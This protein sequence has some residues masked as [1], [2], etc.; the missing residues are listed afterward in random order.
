MKRSALAAAVCSLAM[1]QVV[2][3][4]VQVGG[5][6]NSTLVH[7]AIDTNQDQA[8]YADRDTLQIR[9]QVTAIYQSKKLQ[10]TATAAHLYQK[11]SIDEGSRSDSFSQFNYGANLSVIDNTWQVF[12]GGSQSYRAIQPNAYLSSDFLLNSNDLSKITTHSAGTSLNIQP[13]DFW[14]AVGTVRYYNVKSDGTASDNGDDLNPSGLNS[15]G[16]SGSLS[17]FNGDWFRNGYW[18][19][20]GVF[21]SVDR[22]NSGTY[23]S[24]YATG[25]MGYN[26]ISDFGIVLTASHEENDI[27]GELGAGLAVFNS[28]FGRFNTYGVGINYRPASSR[29]FMITANKISTDGDDDG[30]TFVGV[31]LQWQFSARTRVAGQ[32]TRRYYGEAGTFNFS[33]GTRAVRTSLTYSES[34]TT[35]SRL[36]Y[37]LADAGSFV[38]GIDAVDISD[39][40]QP[41]TLD[42]ELQ[43]GEQLVQF[44]ELVSEINEQLILRRQLGASIGFDRRKLKVALETRYVDTQYSETDRKQITKLIAINGSFRAGARTQLTS[45][46]AYSQVENE[47]NGTTGNSENMVYSLGMRTTLSRALSLQGDIRY[48]DADRGIEDPNAFTLQETRISLGLNY[49]FQSN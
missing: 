12:A 4:D 38:C 26:L 27:E 20:S 32:Y 35:F 37:S 11:I 34:T 10:A 19:A 18:Q 29:Y 9:P 24:I 8:N 6:V 31:D 17:L 28:Q 7:Q 30:K 36:L 23:E 14:G 48:L 44:N 39:C 41:D 43:P 1:S 45:R 2:L 22:A 47:L 40:Y 13:G 25:R 46:I 3:A 15:E 42:Y 33:H 5:S 16:Y 21:Q 49:T